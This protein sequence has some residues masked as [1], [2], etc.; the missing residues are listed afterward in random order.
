MV[1]SQLEANKLRR[2]WSETAVL[3]LRSH[4]PRSKLRYCFDGCRISLSL[5]VMSFRQ[6]TLKASTLTF[7]AR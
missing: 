1:P 3:H 7:A 2:I 5:P 6:V 4:P